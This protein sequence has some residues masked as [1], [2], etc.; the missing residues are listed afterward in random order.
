M[1]ETLLLADDSL[2]MRRVVELTFAEQGLHVVS[3]AD[4]QQAIEY[5]T[6]GRPSLALISVSLQKVNGFDVARF[7]RDHV[8]KRVPVLL[9]AGAFDHLDDAQVRESG[10]AG[11]LV[12]PFEP[13]V[14]I[15]R[16]RELLGMKPAGAADAAA[17]LSLSNVVADAPQDAHGL[18]ERLEPSERPRPSGDY[19]DQ[20]D[21]AFESL[22]AQLARSAAAGRGSQTGIP[23]A[24]TGTAAA[25]R[26]A[27]QS[28]EAPASDVPVP[29]NAPAD[30]GDNPVFEVDNDWFEKPSAT[31]SDFVVT[32]ASDF[33]VP[34]AGS[35][36]DDRSWAPR[37]AEMPPADDEATSAVESGGDAPTPSE[38]WFEA[39]AP[40]IAVASEPIAAPVEVQ[41]VPSPAT[42]PEPPTFGAYGG[43]GSARAESAPVAAAT[44]ASLAPA[45]APFAP[46]DAFAM[47]WA[48][49]QGEVIPAPAPPPPVE[50]G[51]PTVDALSEQV[52]DRLAAHLPS[53]VAAVVGDRVASRVTADLNDLA[54][55][56]VEELAGRVGPQIAERLVERLGD[57]LAADLAPRVADLVAQRALEGVL[58]DALRQTVNEVAE[59]LVRAEI[60]RIRAAANALRQQ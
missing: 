38:R 30:A 21:A 15:R 8:G 54:P 11:V 4:G 9:L 31:A 43:L 39:P 29:F 60:D 37:G 40:S 42:S 14:V 46:A 22:D 56:L 7:V 44:F 41:E 16:V 2:T 51:G 1:S 32:R 35:A 50:L 17:G 34:A 53:P 36:D 24:S 27:P 20:L 55:R 25:E 45:S 23:A 6:A 33:A 57:R 13:S 52:S 47:L 5:L 49:E 19:F 58:G 28:G 3:V 48:Q 18:A 26:S 12:K 59:R 10:A